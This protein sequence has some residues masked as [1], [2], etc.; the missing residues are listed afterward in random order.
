[1]IPYVER[2][3]VMMQDPDHPLVRWTALAGRAQEA[4]L[5][6]VLITQDATVEHPR[7]YE[8]V[9]RLG[10]PQRAH[11]HACLR[12]ACL[13]LVA[14]VS[15]APRARATDA[16]SDAAALALDDALAT[17]ANG[18][19]EGALPKLEAI[20]GPLDFARMVKR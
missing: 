10:D 2:D 16:A 19:V 11:A 7:Q 8:C 13:A 6:V 15:A 9:V 20:H 3:G 14:G 4:G 12:A 17:V 1:M 5:A 18:D